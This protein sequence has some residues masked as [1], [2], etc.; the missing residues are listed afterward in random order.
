MQVLQVNKEGSEYEFHIRIFHKIPTEI[1]TYLFFEGII[2]FFEFVEELQ[3]L[4]LVL[5]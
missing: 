4:A 3:L 5:Y 2:L 1:C